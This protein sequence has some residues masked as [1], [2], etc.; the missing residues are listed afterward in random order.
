MISTSILNANDRV[1]SVIELNKTNTSYI[2]IDVMD[3]KFVDNIQFSIKDIS[4]INE[5]SKYPLDVHLMVNDPFDY[6]EGLKNFDISYITFHLEM[7]KDIKSVISKIR[8]L[9]YNVGVSIKPNTSID[10]L[11]PYLKDIDMV[12]VMSVEPGL[13][14]QKFLNSTVKR[15][16]DLKKIIDKDGYDI[17]IEVDGGIND[18]TITKLDSVDIVVVGSYITKCNNYYDQIE[19]LLEISN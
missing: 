4:D 17:K 3:G 14:G 16:N 5:V 19:K 8:E 12:L 1:K 13:G 7:D 9:G 2:H 11:L 18:E 15:I 6:L 10:E